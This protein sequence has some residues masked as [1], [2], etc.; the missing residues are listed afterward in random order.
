[1]PIHY[2]T[3]NRIRRNDTTLT[4]LV[5]SNQYPALTD[6][7]IKQLVQCI[8]KSNNTNLIN[9]CL[10]DNV[11]NDEGAKYLGNLRHVKSIELGGN[12]LTDNC[13][14][15]LIKIPGLKS[16]GLAGNDISDL[17]FTTLLRSNTITELYSGSTNIT[18]NSVQNKKPSLKGMSTTTK[19]V[20]MIFELAN[21]LQKLIDSL[22]SNQQRMILPRILQ[23]F[24]N[25]Q[26]PPTKFKKY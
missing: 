18:N 11:I 20:S 1:M 2:S 21:K 25:L 16:L 6:N 26:K 22:P 15:Y 24:S 23:N 5:L 12:Q 4:T 9:L 3:L 10:A 13:I 19:T 8:N 14:Q 7:D 17:G